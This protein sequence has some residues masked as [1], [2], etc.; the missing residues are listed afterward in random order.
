MAAVLLYVVSFKMAAL[1]CSHLY[2]R[3][4]FHYP[5]WSL[6]LLVAVRLVCVWNPFYYRLTY[7]Y[8]NMSLRYKRWEKE[9]MEKQKSKK[10]SKKQK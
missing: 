2:R 4:T 3:G 9:Q 1:G 6:V 7:I 10:E 8:I 5:Q